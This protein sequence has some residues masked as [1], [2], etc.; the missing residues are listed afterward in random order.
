MFQC[1][2]N[3]RVLTQ[4]LTTLFIILLSIFSYVQESYAS[5]DSII[6]DSIQT[7]IEAQKFDDALHLMSLQD[8]EVQNSYDHLFLKG[9]ILSWKGAHRQA[10]TVL[11][12]LLSDYPGNDDV[13]LAT[14]SLNYYQGNLNAA[15]KTFLSILSRTPNRSDALQALENVRKA[16]RANRPYTWRI[17][18]GAGQSTFEDTDQTNWNNQYLRAEYAPNDIA[19][20]AS[21]NRYKRFS[22]ENVQF[23]GGISSAKRGDWDWGLQAG[24]TPDA[25]FR[26]KTHYGGRIGKKLDIE[27]G[28]TLVATLHYR[29]DNY[30]ETKIHNISPEVTAYFNNGARLTGRI[31]GTVQNQEKD[32]AGWLVNGSYPVADKWK[33][34]AGIARA[35]EAVNGLVVTT[36]SL[37]GGISYEVSPK[38]D[39]HLNVARDNR[40][41]I[42]VR[43]AINVGFTHKY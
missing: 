13:L 23:E 25:L 3:K 41:D 33:L 37:F 9:R 18:G 11:E 12:G 39:L 27:N 28:P 4:A 8:T 40:E 2:P 35:P 1:H 36:K 10:K 34:N 20:H 19:Y 42:Y 15:E 21:A 14:G 38:L 6:M 32:Q 31:I 22:V 17:D 26:P 29:R 43:N 30:T 24:F 5:E 7:L 16:K